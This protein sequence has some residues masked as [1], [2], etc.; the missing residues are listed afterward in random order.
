MKY[1]RP[2]TY[3]FYRTLIKLVLD[4]LVLLTLYMSVYYVR[5]TI[6]PLFFSLKQPAPMIYWL[7]FSPV[8]CGT[9]LFF[10]LHEGVYRI[11]MKS[12]V[13]GYHFIKAAVETLVFITFIIYM[14]RTA[15]YLSRFAIFSH[16]LLSACVLPLVHKT[17]DMLGARWALFQP[18]MVLIGSKH[19]IH[20]F[21]KKLIPDRKNTRHIGAMYFFDGDTFN[22]ADSVLQHTPHVLTSLEELRAFFQPDMKPFYEILLFLEEKL[23]DEIEEFLLHLEEEGY[24]I[25]VVPPY[26][27]FLTKLSEIEF[28]Q[29][30]PIIRHR[31]VLEDPMNRVVKRTIDIFLCFLFSPLVVLFGIVIASLIYLESG[32]PI[33]FQHRRLGLKGREFWL[34]KFRTMYTDADNILEE[35]LKNHPERAEEYRKFRKLK[36]DPRLTKVG[37]WLRRWSLDELPQVWNILK[38][39][40]SFVGPRPYAVNELHLLKGAKGHILRVRPGLTGLWQ[41]SG[42]N[43]LSFEER[44]QLDLFYIRNWDIWM[45]IEIL[46][47]T[48]GVVLTAKGAY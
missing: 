13:S 31:S 34:L 7:R 32:R 46:L 45:D 9:W 15:L 39:D 43:I 42:R 5:T 16:W 38:G 40:M 21:L 19:H 28:I 11:R 26:T 41:V 6:L 3:F 18:I 33:F 24:T 47:R 2:G 35:Y 44:I 29:S 20:A 1:I 48:V 37:R 12:W 17:V 23:P 36:D 25:L 27:G 10:M 4:A 22:D 30:T 8:V 14:S